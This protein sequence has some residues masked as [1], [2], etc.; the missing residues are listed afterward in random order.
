M[1]A[2][3][4]R[5]ARRIPRDIKVENWHRL[6]DGLAGRDINLRRRYSKLGLSRPTR[7]DGPSN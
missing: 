1:R 3:R 5:V 2:Y 7:G 4:D 6:I